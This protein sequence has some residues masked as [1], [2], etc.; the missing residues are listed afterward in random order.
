MGS[1]QLI[2][3]KYQ[4]CSMYLPF[5]S[6][7]KVLPLKFIYCNLAG[8]ILGLQH[9][10]RQG[11]GLSHEGLNC[12]PIK[13]EGVVSLQFK[14][15]KYKFTLMKELLNIAPYMS[16]SVIVY[17]FS[18]TWPWILVAQVPVLMAVISESRLLAFYSTVT[19]LRYCRRIV[20]YPTTP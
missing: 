18:Q 17:L 16:T 11:P 15:R 10:L 12:L 20:C 1:I 6:F 19:R 14:E 5:K 3:T 4:T 8:Q 7:C 9:L 13:S 2:F